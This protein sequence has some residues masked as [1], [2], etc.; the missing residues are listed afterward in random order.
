M[1]EYLLANID[2]DTAGAGCHSCLAELLLG[3]VK[4][5]SFSLFLFFC[6]HTTYQNIR[7][8]AIIIEGEALR[9]ESEKTQKNGGCHR[10]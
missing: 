3:V 9:I 1:Y 10:E 5:F 8:T 4:L 6:K 2:V 7:Q